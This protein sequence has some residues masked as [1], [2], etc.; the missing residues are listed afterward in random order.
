MR[1]AKS[2]IWFFGLV[3]MFAGCGK[4]EKEVPSAAESMAKNKLVRIIADAV[5]APFEYG[6]GVAV[7][8]LDV[9]IGNEIGKDL[10][11]EVKWVKVSGY[12]HLFEVLKNGEAEILISAIAI[13]P[14]RSEQFAFS[15]PYF[16]T[17]DVIAHRRDNFEIKDLASL[18]GKTIGVC[19][20]R[21]GDTFLQQQKVATG[22]TIKRY[23]TLDDALGALN[24]A[25]ISA[26][27]GDQAILTYSSFKSFPNTTVIPTLINKY[28]YAVVVRK[29]E[30]ELLNKINATLERLQNSGEMETLK[31]RWFGNVDEEARR[32]REKDI[33]EATL[34]KSPKTISVTINKLGGTFNMDRLDGFVLV[35]QGPAGAYQSTPILTEG[36]KGN[37]RFSQPVPPGDYKL[38]MNILK[39]TT[40]VTV[41]DLPKNALA[42]TMNISASGISITFK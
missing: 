4:K 28:Q 13:D 24:R 7:K 3:L 42:M 22:L 30:K 1:I 12:D 19:N 18:S 2:F 16:D 27:V 33:Q 15:K 38:N 9:D 25:E 41:P 20:G 26:V 6:E 5:N 17:G 14:S 8:G 35:L 37:C 36:N 34:R 11:Y 29:N 23:P 31:Q 40:T 21:P 39:L 10:G 32:Q